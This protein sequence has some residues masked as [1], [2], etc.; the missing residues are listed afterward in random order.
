[1]AEGA[2]M[3]KTPDWPIALEALRQIADT[4]RLPD[5]LWSAALRQWEDVD[6]ATMPMFAH[7]EPGMPIPSEDPRIGSILIDVDQLKG[8]LKIRN[9]VLAENLVSSAV[10]KIGVLIREGIRFD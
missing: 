3:M 8:A 5:P 9:R 10:H 6:Q 4:L 1:M 2:S 7:L